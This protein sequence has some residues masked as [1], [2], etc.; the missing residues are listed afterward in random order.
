M[1]I[2]SYVLSDDPVV[3]RE[4]KR[5]N[6]GKADLVDLCYSC[7]GGDLKLR[8]GDADFSIMTGGGVQI[9]DFAVEFFTAGRT[10]ASGESG[11]IAFA[12]MA[13]EIHLRPSCGSVRVSC[14]Y[15]D[16]S[17][18]ILVEEF[19]AA[20]RSFLSKVLV[21]LE[22]RYPALKGNKSIKNVHSWV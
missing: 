1:I 12:G 22:T 16:D 7:F 9:L 20:S 11:R 5:I 8:V 2:A 10:I 14:N 18:E 13:D 4:Q 19:V 3:L 21:D 6:L 15:T 17:A